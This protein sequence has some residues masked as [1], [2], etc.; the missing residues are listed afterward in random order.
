MNNAVIVGG[1]I[2]NGSV[3]F[4]L[5]QNGQMVSV[6]LSPKDAKRLGHILISLANGLLPSGGN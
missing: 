6:C 3:E 4:T 1:H 2:V 5:N